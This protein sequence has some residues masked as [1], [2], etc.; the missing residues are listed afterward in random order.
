MRF[1]DHCMLDSNKSLCF[2][3]DILRWTALCLMGLSQTC[4]QFALELEG[5]KI[6]VTFH[7]A[8]KEKCV[9]DGFASLK[10]STTTKTLK[11]EHTSS[12]YGEFHIPALCCTS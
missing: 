3:P 6:P 12:G 10:T 1:Q 5:C 9:R 11:P 8:R 7:L 4:F 2:G